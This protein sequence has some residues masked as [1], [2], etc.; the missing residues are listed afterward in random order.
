MAG[1]VEVAAIS[2]GTTTKLHIEISASERTSLKI[3][4]E[5]ISTMEELQ[6]LVAEVSLGDGYGRVVHL[7]GLVV[8]HVVPRGLR[9]LEEGA[10]SAVLERQ[11]HRTIGGHRHARDQ[12]RVLAVPV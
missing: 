3:S 10:A 8:S 9:G 11:L 12:V 2:S 7:V 6:E 5:G 1:D 4:L